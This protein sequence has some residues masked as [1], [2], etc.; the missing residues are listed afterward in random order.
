VPDQRPLFPEPMPP[1]N[2]T[3]Q[4]VVKPPVPRDVNVAFAIWVLDA[5]VSLVVRFLDMNRFVDSYQQQVAGTAEDGVLDAGTLKVVYV[6]AVIVAALLMLF[7][8]WMMRSG[9]KWARAVLAILAVIGLM[10][11]AVTVG[12]SDPIAIAGVLL[13]ASGLV[14]M[15]VPASNAYFNQFVKRR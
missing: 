7:F 5:L 6:I 13:A 11:Q 2:R 1:L 15:F 9:R 3:E 4:P 14:F 8:A 12:L 10:S